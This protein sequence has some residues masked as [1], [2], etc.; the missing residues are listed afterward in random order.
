MQ[1]VMESREM[2]GGV[3]ARS[4]ELTSRELE[5]LRLVLDGNC[6]GKV[7]DLLYVSK[8]TVDFHLGRAYRK[9]GVKNRLQAFE[10]AVRLGIV[11]A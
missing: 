11:R 1:S 4:I 3:I 5:I 8:R 10:A 9:L 7:A 2:S 6:S